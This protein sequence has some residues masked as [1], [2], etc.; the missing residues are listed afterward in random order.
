MKPFNPTP[1]VERVETKVHAV[2]PTTR[3]LLYT[4]VSS[5][6]K[7]N[8]EE[9]G[10]CPSRWWFDKVEGKKEKQT[11]AQA[12]GVKGHSQIEHYLP[13]GED[14]LG[15]IAAAGRKYLPPPGSDLMVEWGLNDKPRPPDIEVEID[16]KKVKKQVN[17]Y[18]LEEALLKA[19]GLPLLGFIDWINPRGWYVTPTGE[20]KWDPPNTAEAGDNKFISNVVYAKNELELSKSTQM[21]GYAH[22]LGAKYPQLEFARVS[23]TSF[24]TRNARTAVK[25]TALLRREY[26]EKEWRRRGDD[27]VKRMREVALIRRE[28]D[29]PANLASCNA[30]NKRCDHS[31]YCSKFQKQNSNPLKRMMTDMG[32]LANR[33]AAGAAPAA[34]TPNGA[35]AAGTTPWVP[36]PPSR[37]PGSQIVDVPSTARSAVANQAYKFST[38]MIAMYVSATERDGQVVYMFM[39]IGE[40]GVAAGTPFPV[41][42]DEPVEHLPVAQAEEAPPPPPPAPAPPKP[43]GPP[44]PPPPSAAAKPPAAPKPA[45]APPPPP[46][47]QPPTPTT[48]RTAGA[49]PP[50]PPLAEQT[51]ATQPAKRGRPKKDTAATPAT[52]LQLFIGCVPTGDYEPLDSYIAAVLA[53]MQVAFGVDDIRFPPDQNHPLA[54]QKWEGA[55]AA[56]VRAGPPAPGSYVAFRGGSKISEIVVE[57]L[58]PLC[59][60]NVVRA[61]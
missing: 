34:T 14:V 13:T 5:L 21:V 36:P 33:K 20:S 12:E 27:V 58:V 39:P 4:S 22:F 53:D 61:V 6:Q 25:T 55:L 11:A 9:Y 35:A 32:L 19:D 57:A 8:P 47:G 52:G 3:A 1:A 56:A 42:P 41:G 26:V 28:E 44:A 10:G 31:S 51:A 46:P 24:Q 60:G 18:P 7:F 54:F 2:D 48:V 16:G 37:R 30:Y 38:G 59:G 50:P 23:H 17:H 15:P 43:P 29:V 49:P 40:D 45:G